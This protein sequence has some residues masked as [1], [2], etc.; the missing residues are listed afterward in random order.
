MADMRLLTIEAMF[1][2]GVDVVVSSLRSELLDTMENT[3][4]DF[5]LR[6]P[7][8]FLLSSSGETCTI[9]RIGAASSSL[10]DLESSLN[11][12]G[13]RLTLCVRPRRRGV[14]SVSDDVNKV[15]ARWRSGIRMVAVLLGDVTKEFRRG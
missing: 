2:R 14:L 10:S 1:L 7:L 9:C 6:R 4:E 8:G 12:A 11:K 13:S 5:F 15:S 3:P